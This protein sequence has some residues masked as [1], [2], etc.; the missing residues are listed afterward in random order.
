MQKYLLYFSSFAI[1]VTTK[2]ISFKF[3][4]FS[5]YVFIPPRDNEQFLKLFFV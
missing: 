2:I 5:M 4:E 3:D 1:G